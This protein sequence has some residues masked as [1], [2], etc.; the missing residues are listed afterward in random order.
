MRFLNFT[1]LL[2]EERKLG[3]FNSTQLH[4]TALSFPQVYM[5]TTSSTTTPNNMLDDVPLD[6]Y[7]RQ[8]M[9]SRGY[10]YGILTTVRYVSFHFTE[11]PI[12]ISCL[13]KRFHRQP[14]DSQQR[15]Y[16]NDLVWAVRTSN[17]AKVKSLAQDGKDMTACNKYSESI[18]H[19]ACRRSSFEMVKLLHEHGARFDQVDDFGRTPLHDACWRSEPHFGMIEYILDQQECLL[20]SADSRGSTPLKYVQQAYWEE[21]RAFLFANR[22]KY[23]ACRK[24]VL[25]SGED[26]L[27]KN[28]ADA[29]TEAEMSVITDSS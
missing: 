14:S 7:F 24:P 12:F 6:Q 28:D 5:S 2:I 19:M 16:D 4:K 27:L 3:C 8:L 1:L 9:L 23:W 29:L 15:D 26:K 11:V 17:V 21:W 10:S 20:R 18:M 13:C 22:D 25:T